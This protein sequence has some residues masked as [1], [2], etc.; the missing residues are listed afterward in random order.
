MT[1]TI[2]WAGIIYKVWSRWEQNWTWVPRWGWPALW[3]PWHWRSLMKAEW[4]IAEIGDEDVLLESKVFC[5]SASLAGWNGS[6]RGQTCATELM[7]VHSW[8]KNA[9][10]GP[11]EIHP[12]ALGPDEM[13]PRVLRE[14]ADV[15][16]KPLSM[17]FERS[18]SQAK[19]LMTERRKTLCPFLRWVRWRTLGTTDLSASSL[20]LGRSWNRSS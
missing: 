4:R 19:S 7:G 6:C 11:D 5:F 18:W 3:P 14:L 16:A 2:P 1:E 20:C 8:E 9:G 10:L 13:H 15:V 17:I 12:R